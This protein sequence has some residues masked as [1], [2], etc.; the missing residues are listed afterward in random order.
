M[1]PQKALIQKKRIDL[2]DSLKDFERRLNH[3]RSL[4]PEKK[5]PG[6]IRLEKKEDSPGIY[7]QLQKDRRTPLKV[8]VGRKKYTRLCT[9]GSAGA[10][11]LVRVN[12]AK[13]ITEAK[14]VGMRAMK[15][16]DSSILIDL[17]LEPMSGFYRADFKDTLG[18]TMKGNGRA[19][20]ELIKQFFKDERM[21]NKMKNDIIR[22]FYSKKQ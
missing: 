19:V 15:E 21:V 18:N 11:T 14:E 8:K 2:E 9:E 20:Q 10:E 16:K 6:K 5:K 1:N 13:L 7:A 3:D 12:L 4:L 17:C 22:E